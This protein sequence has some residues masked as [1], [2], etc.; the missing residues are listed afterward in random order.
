M[1]NQ[2]VIHRLE[3]QIQLQ[4]EC[5]RESM[6]E[7]KVCIQHALDLEET[8][9]HIL[10]PKVERDKEIAQAIA[11]DLDDKIKKFPKISFNEEARDQYEGMGEI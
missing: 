5:A 11:L 1:L 4:L 2:R 8:L 10:I 6:D 7:A 9:K 3:E